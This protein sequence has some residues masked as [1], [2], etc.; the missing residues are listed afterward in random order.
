MKNGDCRRRG[1]LIGPIAFGRHEA[2]GD[3]N[4]RRLLVSG[5]RKP[6]SATVDASASNLGTF[7]YVIVGAGTAG[8]VLANRLSADPAVS[9]LLLEAGGKD[10]YPWI[11]IPVGIST[12]RTIRA[13]T[14]A[15]G[16]RP[17]PASAGAR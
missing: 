6:G 5:V 7:D 14:G 9:V 4:H 17:R 1:D 3:R 8:C 12:P 11:H 10:N 2:R 16:P 13:P 15:S